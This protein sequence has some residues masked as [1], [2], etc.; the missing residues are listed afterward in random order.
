MNGRPLRAGVESAGWCGVARDVG[1]R[2]SGHSTTPA[3]HRA[4]FAVDVGSD[5]RCAGRF[6]SSRS[7]IARQA[8]QRAPG[9]SS[10][11][12]SGRSRARLA[13]GSRSRRS[14]VARLCSQ[15]TRT[16]ALTEPT[17]SSRP[18]LARASHQRRAQVDPYGAEVLKRPRQKQREACWH[19][20]QA[21]GTL[22]GEQMSA[23]P[24]CR[25]SRTAASLS[26]FSGSNTGQR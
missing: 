10:R 7:M 21:F 19:A 11:R 14:I 5:L 15:S 22:R 9:G 17:S 3:L 2:P 20:L 6:V 4:V 16:I 24:G 8:R 25:S 1:R 18:P 23:D 13:A 12:P 26:T